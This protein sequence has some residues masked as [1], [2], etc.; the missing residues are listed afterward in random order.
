M[1]ARVTLFE[2]D[3]VRLS[4]DE[5]VRRFDTDVLPELREQPGYEGAFVLANETGQGLVLTLWAEADDAEDGVRTGFYASQ[6]D[7]FVT[8]FHAPPGR[9]SYEVVVAD[10]PYLAL[11][12]D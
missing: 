4:L 7:K 8:V 11:A 10:A 5:G 12:P 3:T 1:H 9:E 6:V 2:L